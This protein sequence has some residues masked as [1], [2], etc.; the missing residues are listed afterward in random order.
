[1]HILYTVY[2]RSRKYVRYIV[3]LFSENVIKILDWPQL[4][5]LPNHEESDESED[6]EP[7][8]LIEDNKPRQVIHLQYFK[9]F[10]L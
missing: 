8:D 4:P 6:A 3:P 9:Y 1:M 2:I 7:D 5:P 10:V